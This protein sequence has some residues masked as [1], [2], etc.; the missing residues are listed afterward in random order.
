MKEPTTFEYPLTENGP[1]PTEG[2]VAI[3]LPVPGE[4]DCGHSATFTD[5]TVKTALHRNE[6]KLAQ[7]FPIE[8][9]ESRTDKIQV[10]AIPELHLRDA[11]ASDERVRCLRGRH[12]RCLSSRLTLRLTRG[13]RAAVE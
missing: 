11:P 8:L 12:P 6:P 7:A 10:S 5:P 13:R 9:D 3:V 2:L 4:L 1:P